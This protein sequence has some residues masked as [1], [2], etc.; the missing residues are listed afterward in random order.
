[1]EIQEVILRA[2]AKKIT[3]TAWNTIGRTLFGRARNP[4][5]SYLTSPQ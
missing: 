4:V 3:W 1:M 2:V 5:S